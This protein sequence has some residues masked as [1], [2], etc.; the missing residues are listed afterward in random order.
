MIEAGLFL[1]G[2]VIGT[3]FAFF[4][5]RKRINEIKRELEH[6]DSMIKLYIQSADMSLKRAREVVQESAGLRIRLS[7]IEELLNQP[8][9]VSKEELKEVLK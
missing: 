2:L 6:S 4:D 1:V 5:C 9:E 7:K 8:G 3:L